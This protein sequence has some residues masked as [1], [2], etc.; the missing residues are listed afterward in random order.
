MKILCISLS[1]ALLGGCSIGKAT[2][3]MVRTEARLSD[4]NAKIESL[5]GSGAT[6][7]Q[8]ELAEALRQVSEGTKASIASVR[9]AIEEANTAPEKAQRVAELIPGPYGQLISTGIGLLFGGGAIGVSSR[10]GRKGK[11]GS[12]N[13]GM[14]RGMD[15]SS[16]KGTA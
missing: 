14:K 16:G 9:E 11:E 7:S 12:F 15:I 5:E 2:D 10:A 1:L 8:K 6:D 13:E 4:L 3:A